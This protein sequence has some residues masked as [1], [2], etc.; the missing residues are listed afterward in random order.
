MQ[1]LYI[2]LEPGSFSG[3]GDHWPYC[4][5]PLSNIRLSRSFL[6]EV[7]DN[8]NVSRWIGCESA[9]VVN[10]EGPGWIRIG[11][12]R[13]MQ[14]MFDVR[15]CCLWYGI[16]RILDLNECLVSNRTPYPWFSQSLQSHKSDE[17]SMCLEVFKS[18]YVHFLMALV[19]R[20]NG[21][22]CFLREACL[23][24]RLDVLE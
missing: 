5:N 21:V 24:L 6:Q 2:I 1:S 7:L 9:R 11:R 13:Q 18:Y 23:C 20:C 16:C 10:E 12:L 3:S 17:Y 15:L 4:M 8:F 22:S 14:S 19:Q